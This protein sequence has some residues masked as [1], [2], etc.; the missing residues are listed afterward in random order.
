VPADIRAAALLVAADAA[1]GMH[2]YPMAATR[3]SQLVSTYPNVPD[4]P[5]ATLRL[6]WSQYREGHTAAARQSWT[7]LANRYPTDPRAPL[8]LALAAEI[9]SRAGDAGEARVLSDR[10]V[11]RY[12]TSRYSGAARLSRAIVAVRQQR[13]PD[14]IRDLDDLVKAGGVAA[15]DE[16]HQLLQALSV[17]RTELTLEERATSPVSPGTDVSASPG[18]GARDPVDRF[19]AAVES[20]DR[21]GAP[22]VIHGLLLSAVAERGWSSPRAGALA[23]RLAD[24][25]PAYPPAPALLARV[26]QESAAAGQ[27][28][29]ARKAYESLATRYPNQSGKIDMELA[30][31]LHRTGATAAARE[32]LQKAAAAGGPDSARA[33]LKLA[34]ISDAAGD[35]RAALTAY[36]TLARNYPGLPWQPESLIAHARLL[37]EFGPPYRARAALRAVAETSRGDAAAEAAYRL[38]RAASSEGQHREA[39][40]WYARAA[41]IAPGSKWERA[42]LLGAGDSYAQL[43]DFQRARSAYDKIL[44]DADPATRAEASYGVGGIA[45]A[46]GRH[47]DAAA[48]FLQAAQL[49][50]GSSLEPRALV[51]A[52]NCLV[53]AGDRKSADTVYQRLTQAPKTEPGDLAAAR[54]ALRAEPR[55][56]TPGAAPGG[57]PSTIKE[58]REVDERAASAP[59]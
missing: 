27:W 26:A 6:G 22:F 36:D 9:A 48:L 44:R 42:G 11:M 24:D 58:W 19:V 5:R 16:R 3:Y 34:E 53:A 35:R 51:G 59:R 7:G 25:F 40:E 47:R 29:T 33:L 32:R 54:T 4:A 20:R 50:P 10:I 45:H 55:R 37:E 8:A 38:G 17:P 12:P 46:E 23:V 57:T 18:L 30:D 2:A 1:Y 21:A 41:A 15:V 56:A 39:A 52:V 31:A 13:E 28:P 49:A 43:R 14:A